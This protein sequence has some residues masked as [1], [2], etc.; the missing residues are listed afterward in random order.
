MD[1]T[2]HEV[3]LE[4]WRAV[5]TQC[6]ERPSGQTTKSWLAENGIPEKTYYYWLRKIRKLAYE[7]M[8]PE[9]PMVQ[10]E[11]HSEIVMAEIPA[12]DILVRDAVLAVTIRT[13]RSTIEITNVVSDK[14]LVE[15]VKAVSRAL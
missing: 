11:Q 5:I 12:E 15:L 3:R 9:L 7:S 2:T 1:Q 13:K 6:Q 8:K 10:H 14:A 4:Q